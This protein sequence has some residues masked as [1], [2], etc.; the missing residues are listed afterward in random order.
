MSDGVPEKPDVAAES[1]T[2]LASAARQ[3]ES[4]PNTHVQLGSLPVWRAL[5]VR[6]RRLIGPWCFLDRFG[7]LTFSADRPMDVAPHPHIGLQTVTWLLDGEVLH[8]DSLGCEAIASPGSVNVMTAGAGIAHAEQT[9]AQNSGRLNGV[10]LWVALPN[11]HRN[12]EP[13]FEAIA[14]VPV[15]EDRGSIIKVFAG[16]IGRTHS[17]AHHYSEI[18]G[19]QIDIEAGQKVEIGVNPEYEH[20]VLVLSGDCSIEHQHLSNLHLHY[21]GM[22]RQSVSFSSG[23]GGTMLLIG[24]PPFPETVLMWWNFV[25]RT[26]EEIA[27]ARADWEEHRRFGDVS[28]YR[29]ARLGAPSLIQ[30]ARPNPMS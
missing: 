2:A 29:G 10:Q 23:A 27:A 20:A 11:A 3:L 8:D 21:L 28:A 17:P 26:P 30:F 5:P 12:I 22:Q 14:H 24:G 16:S 9:P 13:S 18:V 4:F 19:A 6:G 7:P 25:A 15:I 1:C